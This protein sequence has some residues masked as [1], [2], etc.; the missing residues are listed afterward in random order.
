MYS[1]ILLLTSTPPLKFVIRHWIVKMGPDG[2]AHQPRRSVNKVHGRPIRMAL[3]RVLE[4]CTRVGCLKLYR[5]TDIA[6][7]Y[8]TKRWPLCN[9]SI[10]A[11]SEVLLNACNSKSSGALSANPIIVV[12]AIRFLL[13]K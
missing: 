4:E 13:V 8:T 2:N 7:W 10:K 1:R 6:Y 12:R 9:K 5:T 3:F 11:L